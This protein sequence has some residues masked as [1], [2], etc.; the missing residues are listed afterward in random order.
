MGET[1]RPFQVLGPLNQCNPQRLEE[2][3][4]VGDFGNG[5]APDGSDDSAPSVRLRVHT[6]SVT[7]TGLC[8]DVVGA[9]GV[10]ARRRLLDPEMGAVVASPSHPFRRRGCGGR[11]LDAPTGTPRA[12]LCLGCFNWLVLDLFHHWRSPFSFLQRASTAF[13]AISRR[14]SGVSFFIRPAALF[15]PPLRPKATACGFFFATPQ[16]Y[17][18][19]SESSSHP[20]LDILKQW[21]IIILKR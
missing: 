11:K 8:D 7:H 2:V 1:R 19:G 14:C 18:S 17:R 21:S 13:R 3:T 5:A 15:L 12:G 16:V 10:R 20:P 6:Q 9:S 4:E